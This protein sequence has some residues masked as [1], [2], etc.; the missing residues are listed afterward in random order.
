MLWSFPQRTHRKAVSWLLSACSLTSKRPPGCFENILVLRTSNK[1]QEH[2]NILSPI[3]TISGSPPTPR[4]ERSK[5]K[6]GEGVIFGSD[7]RWSPNY[8]QIY[9]FAISVMFSKNKPSIWKQA[10]W[11][12][13]TVFLVQQRAYESLWW[14]FPLNISCIRQRTIFQL[15]C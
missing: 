15:D 3:L 4:R 12:V 10:Q 2:Q 8:C 5:P 11:R 14:H 7:Y 1:L 13:K 9:C 6:I